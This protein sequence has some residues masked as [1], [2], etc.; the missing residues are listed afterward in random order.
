[1]RFDGATSRSNS[2]DACAVSTNCSVEG[3]DEGRTSADEDGWMA[4]G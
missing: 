3:W 2:T 4:S 1:M